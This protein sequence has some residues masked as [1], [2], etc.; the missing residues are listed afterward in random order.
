MVAAAV[1]GRVGGMAVALGLGLGTAWAAPGTALASPESPDS[2]PAG[3]AAA[4]RSGTTQ[5]DRSPA[6]RAADGPSTTRHA[7]RTTA[8]PSA[9][10]PPRSRAPAPRPPLNPRHNVVAGE[11][12]SFGEIIGYT[13]FH[14]APTAS[15]VQ[16]PGQSAIGVVTGNLNAINPNGAPMSYALAQ[17]PARGSVQLDG[18]GGYG[19]TP[20]E[21]LAAAG[22][23]DSFTV[24]IDNGGPYRLTGVAGII[25]SL[26]ATF[27]Q[28][29]GLR[30]PDSLSVVVPVAI[31][32]AGTANSPPE[33]GTP[34]VGTPDAATG[35]VIGQIVATD[36]DGN[37][38]IYSAP[39]TTAKGT[40][41]MNAASGA[42]TY[43]PTAEARNT[44][45]NPGATA[46][47]KTDSFTA[48][49]SDG[50]ASA[51]VIVGVTVSPK[52]AAEPTDLIFSFDYGSGSRYWTESSRSALQ[53]AADT[54]ASYLLVDYPVTLTFS[55]T[56]S[57][58]ATSDTLASAGSELTST[59]NGFFRTVV[60]NKVLD[61]TDSN[62][63]AADGEIDV[64]FGIDWAF[65][66][67]VGPEQYDFR[68]TMLHELLHAFGFLSY[69][70][71][72]GNNSGR[73]WVEFDRFVVDQN[74]VAVIGSNFR[75]NTAYNTNLTGG[76]GGLLFGG[77][78]A[79]EAYGGLVPLYT[80]NPWE[81]GSSGSHVDDFTF[82]DAEAQLMNAA[83]S[84]GPGVR[85][86]SAIELGILRDI[87][88]SV[89][90][91]PSVALLFLG[92]L[93]LRRK[94]S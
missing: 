7:S 21:D 10:A 13:F 53:W 6:D 27:A 73:N 58:S 64:N 18:D 43:T 5:R 91:Q 67:S 2:G 47:D 54:L 16:N 61:G 52:A 35:V 71:E 37:T 66:D 19:Y 51:Q 22:G 62:G 33:V 94:R 36:P 12:P 57:S 25:Q 75:F 14:R 50:L 32:A 28:L 45:A 29:V 89:D 80:P 48:T 8:R 15:P 74:G 69:I 9:E 60:Q 49:V 1:V 83:T 55:I 82:T 42:F 17:S 56:A 63:S 77:A 44:A 26:F 30:Q 34:V 70:D 65:G 41:T 59:A 20:D 86:I 87:G 76:G 4:E 39:G 11:T 88:Y 79:V 92:L 38:L 93:V 72:R 90:P 84:P 23:T 40:V 81:A 85:V 46:A 24:T 31:A 68:S 78:N 3:K